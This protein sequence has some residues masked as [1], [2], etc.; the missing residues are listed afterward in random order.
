M[1]GEW[2]VRESEPTTAFILLL[3]TD[4][5]ACEEKSERQMGKEREGR[6]REG[7]E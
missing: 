3:A 4:F 6:E 5:S 2:V 7:E 1:E